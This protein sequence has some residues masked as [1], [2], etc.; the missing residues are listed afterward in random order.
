[1]GYS[2]KPLSS[3]GQ[4]TKKRRRR[5]LRMRLRFKQAFLIGEMDEMKILWLE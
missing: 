3:P 2:L 4:L 5:E 1:M